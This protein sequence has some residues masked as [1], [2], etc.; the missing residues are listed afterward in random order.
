VRYLHKDHLGS[1]DT[2]TD[3]TGAIKERLSFDPHGKR[4]SPAWQAMTGIMSATTKGYTGHEMD[5]DIGLIN[6]RAREYD[7]VLG[8]F[9]TPDT[10]IQFPD[11]GQSYNRYTYVNNNP[12]SFTDPSGHSRLGDFLKVTVGLPF[13]GPTALAAGAAAVYVATQA[14]M[15][16]GG[17]FVVTGY[18]LGGPAGAAAGAYSFYKTIEAYDD[19]A[20]GGD[21]FR[22]AIASG[23][24]AYSRINMVAG[25]YQAWMNN[26]GMKGL[27]TYAEKYAERRYIQGKISAAVERVAEKNGMSLNEFNAYL[28]VLS[29][30][31]NGIAGTRYD[32]DEGMM[33]GFNSREHNIIGLPFDVV[34]TVL[35]FQGLPTASS[36]EY[37]MSSQRGLPLEGHSLGA[38]DATNLYAAG[39]TELAFAQ[40]L[41]F[42]VVATMPGNSINIGGA[43]PISGSYGGLLFN[44][45][46]Y[47]IPGAGHGRE[48]YGM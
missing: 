6:M 36:L 10:I 43:D 45:D 7:P 32:A 18:V 41:P 25:G 46:A 30:V 29:E 22:V 24:Y 40:A 35:A 19:G 44:F 2:I 15:Q 13:V 17:A 9:L 31:G 48:N 3:E 37:M 34:D 28:F 47:V 27:A 16:V 5:D 12:L 1:I 26:G 4:R 8:R 23:L 38:I 14:V 11:N 33:W 42:G 21:L 39:L 20:R